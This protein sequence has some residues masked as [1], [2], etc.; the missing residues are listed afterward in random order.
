MPISSITKSI[1]CLAGA[2]A[3]FVVV[4]P[5]CLAQATDKP[6]TEPVYRI[7]RNNKPETVLCVDQIKQRDGSV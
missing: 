2:L 6:T 4:V 3:L 5:E 7:G 1:Y